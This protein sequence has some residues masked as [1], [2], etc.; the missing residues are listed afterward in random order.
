MDHADI[1]RLANEASK[2]K[3]PHFFQD[4]D[5][6]RLLSIVW[7]MA[8]ELAVTRE[9]LDTVERLLARRELLDRAAIDAFRPTADEARER[10]QWH[11]EYISRLLRVLQQEVEALQRARDV[12]AEDLAPE[13]AG[14]PAK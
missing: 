13:L 9:R 6:D 4:P 1:L 12:S 5:V 8:G 3:R 7:A 14:D 11:L 10:G 2:G